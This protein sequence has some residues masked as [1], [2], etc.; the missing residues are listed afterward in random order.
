MK[1]LIASLIFLTTFSVQASVM[2]E[3]AESLEMTLNQELV[4]L[5]GEVTS[6][7]CINHF[8]GVL[9]YGKLSIEESNSFTCEETYYYLGFGEKLYERLCST[10]S[11]TQGEE[12]HRTSCQ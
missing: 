8:V 10:C 12:I 4:E 1:T 3:Y 7:N 9:C 5:S 11:F 6:L 2:S